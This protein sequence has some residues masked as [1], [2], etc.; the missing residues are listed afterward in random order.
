MIIFP[1]L[2]IPLITCLFIHMDN[3]LLTVVSELIVVWNR[4][5]Q[6]FCPFKLANTALSVGVVNVSRAKRVIGDCKDGVNFLKRKT[7]YNACSINLSSIEQVEHV[8]LTLVSGR[9]KKVKRSAKSDM[10]PN[11]HPTLKWMLL[12][13]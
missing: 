2:L 3:I 1:T 7:L 5:S 13:M 12:S 8:E 4:R 11:I 10:L 9:K 6:P